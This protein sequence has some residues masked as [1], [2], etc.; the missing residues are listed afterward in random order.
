MVGRVGVRDVELAGHLGGAELGAGQQRQDPQAHRVRDGPQGAGGRRRSS[1]TLQW[2]LGSMHQAS[3][4]CQTVVG[5]SL[6]SRHSW[7]AE[8][9]HGLGWR[10][11]CSRTGRHRGD[12]VLTIRFDRPEAFN[13]LTGEMTLRRRGAARAG[14]RAR[15]RTRRA[16][17]RHR[18]RVQPGRR[19]RRG[20]TRTRAS[21]S[22]ALDAANRLIRAIVGC[23]KP[24]VAGVNGIAAG[25]G[26]LRGAGLRPRGRAPSVGASCSR[27]RGSG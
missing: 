21:T 11:D 1:A 3:L 9:D 13:A 5:E 17:D 16:A 19:H 18:G 25:V 2:F 14:V 12:G 10:H 7:P 6:L 27:S 24:V 4:D 15:R 23:D 20:R 26:L 8:A 22:R